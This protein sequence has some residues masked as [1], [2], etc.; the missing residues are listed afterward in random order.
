LDD[1]PEEALNLHYKSA[2]ALP[3]ISGDCSEYA[4][5]KLFPDL[6]NPDD[7]FTNQEKSDFIKLVKE[8]VG[9]W[10]TTN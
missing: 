8:R 7:I 9:E 3:N 10:G 5:F 6:P 1:V 4:L 2:E